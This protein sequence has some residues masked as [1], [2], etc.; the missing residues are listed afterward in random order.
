MQPA[1]IV[2]VGAGVS[3]LIAAQHL[4]AAGH[5]PVILEATDRIGGRVKTDQ[6]DGFACDHGF[7]VL[8]TAYQEAQRYLS[9]SSLD[10][11]PFRPGAVVFRAGKGYPIVDPLREPA[12]LL[13]A[14]LSPVASLGDKFLTWKLQRE[15][16]AIDAHQLF[17][18]KQQMTTKQFLVEYGFSSSY[19]KSFFEPFFGGIF[20]E[21]ELLTPAPMLRFVFKMFAEGHAAVPRGG[22]EAIPKALGAALKQSELR[23]QTKV[24]AVLDNRVRTQNGEDIP[25]DALIIATDPQ[26]LLPQLAGEPLAYHATTTLYYKTQGQAL[27]SLLIGLVED[28]DSLVNNF[29]EL[30]PLDAGYTPAGSQLL[31]VTLKDIPTLAHAEETVAAELRRIVG[32]PDWK[33]EPVTRYDIPKA[34][35]RLD[36]LTYDTQPSESRM[37]E[38]I[39]LAGDHL[40]LGS[41]DAAMRSGRRAAEGVLEAIRPL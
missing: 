40:L 8:L 6:I 11:K 17:A 34:L 13:T 38:Q 15:L 39:F 30:A 4:E 12:Q 23:L 1:R 27:P 19:I 2:I 22:M 5:A 36:H 32:Q 28:A 41:L 26:H 18:A 29:C 3:G 20:L 25:F 14:L 35:P 21:N 31:S 33:L 16:K 10:L 24:E 37:T 9:Y 7:Q